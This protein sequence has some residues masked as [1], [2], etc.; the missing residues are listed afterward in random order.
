MIP[1][2]RELAKEAKLPVVDIHA[3]LADD[4][5]LSSDGVHFKPAGYAKMV[6]AMADAVRKL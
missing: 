4:A 3:H 5:A 6:A 2:I 1:L